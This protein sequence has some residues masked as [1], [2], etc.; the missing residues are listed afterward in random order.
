MAEEHGKVPETF[1]IEDMDAFVERNPDVGWRLLDGDA[2]SEERRSLEARGEI[3][4]MRTDN[5]EE[6]VREQMDAARERRTDEII[7]RRVG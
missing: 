5:L 2:T 3:R 1:F 4:R 7:R 6:S